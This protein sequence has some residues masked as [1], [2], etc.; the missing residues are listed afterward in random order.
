M[1]HYKIAF[2]GL[3]SIGKRQL[4]NVCDYLKQ[5][6]ESYEV[7]LYRSWINKGLPK[8]IAPLVSNVFVYSKDCRIYR[9]DTIYLERDKVL[10]WETSYRVL[11]DTEEAD[12]N[13][14]FAKTLEN[15]SY[16]VD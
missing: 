9:T 8:D 2:V 11:T 13:D 4:I 16:I 15:S 6:H 3:G 12:L 10:E 1:R 5:R 14:A 7:D